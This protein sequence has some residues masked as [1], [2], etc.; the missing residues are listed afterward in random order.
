MCKE[1]GVSGQEGVWERYGAGREGKMSLHGEGKQRWSSLVRKE[2]DGSVFVSNKKKTW[3][4]NRMG[5]S[6]GK[7]EM[8]KWYVQQ[9]GLGWEMG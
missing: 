2:K 9:Y 7:G 4:P 6:H 1:R 5:Q 8:Q 3:R